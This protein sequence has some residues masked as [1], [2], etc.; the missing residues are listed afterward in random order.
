R[1]LDPARD[2][3]TPAAADPGV[4]PEQPEDHAAAMAWFAAEYPVLRATVERA[5][6]AGFDDHVWHLAWSLLTFQDIQGYWHDLIVT[7]DAALAAARHQ[8]DPSRQAFAR[9]ALARACA[10]L[11]RYDDAIDH[12]EHTLDLYRDLGDDVGRAITHLG[13]AGIYE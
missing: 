5:A 9:R 2:L 6:D 8:D 1:L 12:Y 3:V 7:Q 10:R 13:F 11:G 4:H